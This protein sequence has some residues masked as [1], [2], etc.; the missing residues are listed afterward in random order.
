LRTRH[1]DDDVYVYPTIASAEQSRELFVSVMERVNKL[2]ADPEF[3]HSISNNCTSNL[4]DHINGLKPNRVG[5]SW[6]ALLPGFSAEYAYDLGL[7]DN[8]V[9]FEDLHTIAYI[10]DLA[11]RYHDSVDFSQRIRSR[12]S[13]I[14]RLAQGQ[15][16]RNASLNASGQRFL[17]ERFSNER[18]ATNPRIFQ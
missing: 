17:E 1:R 9:P 6:R 8:R 11:E 7:L 16:Q 14:D 5:F 12:H 13:N 2:H 4:V 3:Y 10:N 18:F 15:L